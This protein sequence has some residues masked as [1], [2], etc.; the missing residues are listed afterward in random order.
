M[1]VTNIAVTA[2]WFFSTANTYIHH[3]EF[4][5]SLHLFSLIFVKTERP[6]E[7]TGIQSPAN[8]MKFVTIA[9]TMKCLTIGIWSA[10][11][12]RKHCSEKRL[13]SSYN[14]LIILLLWIQPLQ[15]KHLELLK[16]LQHKPAINENTC[17]Y[18]YY[19][20]E[21]IYLLQRHSYMKGI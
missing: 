1:A 20:W 11:S 17:E 8:T 4:H 13:F 9:N 3:I 7:A 16:P 6:T 12:F 2:L 14:P 19:L 5:S 15:H 10:Y 21:Y 18:L